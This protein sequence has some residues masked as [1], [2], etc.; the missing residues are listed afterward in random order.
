VKPGDAEIVCDGS[1]QYLDRCLAVVGGGRS[2]QQ[3][4]E[5]RVGLDGENVPARAGCYSGSKAEQSK[6]GANI[7]DDIARL[8]HLRGK[9]EQCRVDAT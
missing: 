3:P 6:V 7:P 1:G 4:Y 5:Q 2:A 9:P 8:N